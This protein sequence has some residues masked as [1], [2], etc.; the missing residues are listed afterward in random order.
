MATA[1]ELTTVATHAARHA[2]AVMGAFHPA[3]GDGAPAGCGTLV[4]LGP[5]EPG[6][7]P[8]F[9][10][11]PEAGDGAPNPIDRWSRRVIGGLAA[12][13]GAAALFPFGGPPWQPFT[14]WALRSGRV[15]DSPVHLLV[16]DVAG[17]FFSCRGALALDGRLAL[18][19]PGTRP[20]TD[21][22]APCLDACPPRALTA[23]A[24]DV[25]A[26]HGFLGSAAGAACLTR[27]CAVRRACPVGQG[28]RPEAQSAYHMA[29]FHG[30]SRPCD[31]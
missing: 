30:T 18:P 19:P 20:C 21:C 12:D 27:G 10:A 8:H 15:W 16:H 14:A 31:G 11:S 13:L 3:P 28:R 1:S 7:W 24:Y 22:P 4:L 5:D 2:L 25:P 6:F 23:A 9:R 29:S 17:L 26:C